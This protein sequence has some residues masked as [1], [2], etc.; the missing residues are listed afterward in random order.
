MNSQRNV[1]LTMKNYKTYSLFIIKPAPLLWFLCFCAL[2]SC[3]KKNFSSLPYYDFKS[4]N[5][6]P[7]YTR[8][9]F[10]AAHPFKHDPS[11]SIP[12]PL[13]NTLAVDS[14][15]DVFFLYPTSYTD[16]SAN[17]WNASID[18]PEI[19]AK[20]DYSS[21]LYQ[22]SA[23]N[24]QCRVFAPR[25]RQ[26]NIRAFFVPDS[27]SKPAFDLAYADIKAAFEEYLK[28][29][30]DGRP[31]IIASHS[32]GTLHA[33][34]LIR[35]FFDG[36]PLQKKLVCAYLI[37]MPVSINYFTALKPCSDSSETGCFVSWRSFKSGY[38]GDSI[39]RKETVKMV[40]V[41]PLSWKSDSS[42][43][44]ATFNKGGVL[45]DFNKLLPGV[46][47]AQVHRNMLWTSKPDM[48]GKILLTMK[49][50]HVGDINLFYLNI[51][52]NVTTRINAYKRKFY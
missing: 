35:E 17:P 43:V 51:R 16:I 34:R 44:A 2:A 29:F 23:F 36:K 24:V 9:D 49:N 47:S 37:G 7:D 18:D 19:N 6:K 26:A 42:F 12:L 21:I 31:I 5:G 38:N 15:I 50:Y 33:G 46:V 3:S 48:P 8:L 52:E 28:T 22:A 11:D 39:I 10:W 27:V 20:T 40:V 4:A 41:N 1:D 45:R 32:Q 30:N 14:G 13:R 25:Y